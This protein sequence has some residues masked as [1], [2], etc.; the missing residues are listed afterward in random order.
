MVRATDVVVSMGCGDL[1]PVYPGK[2]YEDS[3]LTDPAGQGIDL[4]RQVRDEVKGRAEA[5][6]DT[7]SNTSG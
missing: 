6:I 4:V 1:C 5:L 7:L 2:R 3:E